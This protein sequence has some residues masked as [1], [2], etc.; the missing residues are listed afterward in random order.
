[1]SQ[2]PIVIAVCTSMSCV[3]SG[4]ETIMLHLQQQLGIGLNETTADGRF[5]LEEIKCFD[6]CSAA[7]TARIG[8][9]YYRQL[10]PEKLDQLLDKFRRLPM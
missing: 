1:M 4:A 2:F 10:T 9:A 3:K 5:R 6:A 7:P 8:E